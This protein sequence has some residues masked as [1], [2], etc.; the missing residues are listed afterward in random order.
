MTRISETRERKAEYRRTYYHKNRDRLLKLRREHYRFNRRKEIEY[1]KSYQERNPDKVDTIKLR[2]YGMSL[3][4]YDELLLK[5]EGVCAI[6]KQVDSCGRRLS[7]DH[8]H[9]TGKIR[10]LLCVKCN[11]AM[12][13]MD[14][15]IDKLE[16]MI[17]YL[18]GHD[19]NSG[20]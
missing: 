14:D 8:D 3:A 18:R 6:C 16:S 4:E 20:G 9:V 19:E 15:S 10:G 1:Q 5:Q 7:V 11:V 2:R 17:K 13:N 12:G